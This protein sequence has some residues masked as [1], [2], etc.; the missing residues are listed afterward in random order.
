HAH[1]LHRRRLVA[2]ARAGD[3][4]AGTLAVNACTADAAGNYRTADSPSGG[5]GCA[6]ARRRAG[7]AAERRGSND[8]RAASHGGSTEATAGA[9]GPAGYSGADG[10][11]AAAGTSTRADAD[12]AHGTDAPSTST[13]GEP[14][15]PSPFQPPP[16][17]GIITGTQ[18]QASQAQSFGN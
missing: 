8:H 3:D 14:A 2:D 5:A 10:D 9:A 15:A 1:L 17:L 12:S 13:A 11:T 4:N 18:I 7:D 6:T 16:S